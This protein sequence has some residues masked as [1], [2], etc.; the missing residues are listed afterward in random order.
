MTQ[1]CTEGRLC[2]VRTGQTAR[3]FTH[4]HL[5]TPAACF[6]K[7]RTHLGFHETL[8]PV[9]MPGGM[10]VPTS[11]P[12]CPP[13]MVTLSSHRGSLPFQA[14]PAIG[15]RQSQRPTE[16]RNINSL[17]SELSGMFLDRFSMCGRGCLARLTDSAGGRGPEAG[18]KPWS[19]R[20]Q[21]ERDSWVWTPTHNS[22]SC[23]LFQQRFIC[24]LL[25]PSSQGAARPAVIS[26]VDRNVPTQPAACLKLEAGRLL[27]SASWGSSFLQH[28]ASGHLP[29]CSLW[30]GQ[31]FG[32][33][34]HVLETSGPHV[35][36]HVPSP[37]F[38][39]R[40]ALPTCSALLD[41]VCDSGPALCP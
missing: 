39:G 12:S 27:L 41:D 34:C 13:V 31:G 4:M 18:P 3:P 29:S 19:P 25:G 7:Q 9:S 35:C 33:L 26:P 16:A 20:A 21:A 11:L 10:L 37:P 40:R 30:G 17:V 24:H 23:Q 15:S 38:A 8:V 32:A 22:C 6:V 1:E 14:H 36:A 5:A 2:R 28:K